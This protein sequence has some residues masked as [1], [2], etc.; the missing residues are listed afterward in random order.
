MADELSELEDLQATLGDLAQSKEQMRC[1]QCQGAGCQG[2]QGGFGQGQGFGDGL[3]RGAGEGY[4]PESEDETNTYE[5]Q[6]RGKVKRGKAIIAGFA[7]GPNRKGVSRE[8][9]K[10]AV[11]SAISEEADPAENQTLPRTEREHTQQYFEQLRQR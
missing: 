2:C 6:V 8:D 7:D 11:E 3:G 10:A 5:S 9:I 1:Q 4:R